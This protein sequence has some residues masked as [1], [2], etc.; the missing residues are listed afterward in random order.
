[1]VNR[2][3]GINHEG[4]A[5][6]GIYGNFLLK[7]NYFYALSLMIA[8]SK[9]LQEPET[10][11][12]L[13]GSNLGDRT[14]NIQKAI[15]RV[16]ERIGEPFIVSSLYETEP[17]GFMHENPFLN[18]ALGLHT[19]VSPHTLL[20]EILT[21]ERESGRIRERK[22]YAARSLDIDILFY[23]RDVISLDNLVIPH[24]LICERRFVLVPLY[25]I[26]PDFIHPVRNKSIRDLL[27]ECEDRSWVLNFTEGGQILF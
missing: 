10:V 17:W 12:L 1:M 2:Y 8:M 14:E 16:R 7:T 20:G 5:S 25:E 19:H 22:G 4:H 15:T 9:N 6:F 24:P 21:I 18:Q 11:Y 23:G 13:F 3:H 26:A 27:K